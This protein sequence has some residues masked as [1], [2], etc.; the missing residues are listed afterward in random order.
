MNL[1]RA[2][3]LFRLLLAFIFYVYDFYD[4][5]GIFIIHSE[6][7]MFYRDILLATSSKTPDLKFDL[8]HQCSTRLDLI[9]RV[10]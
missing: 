5:A 10:T 1:T 3:D 7:E 2:N 4:L 8:P 6:N 9:V